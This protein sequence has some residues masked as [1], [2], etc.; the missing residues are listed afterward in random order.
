MS[1]ESE[2]ARVILPGNLIRER[3]CQQSDPALS[4]SLKPTRF[5]RSFS[6]KPSFSFLYAF[7][8]PP[9]PADGNR[10]YNRNHP[11]KPK[12]DLYTCFI[13]AMNYRC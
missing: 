7:S 6:L 12:G 8:L 3:K 2:A 10:N 9:P 1:Q 13:H 4:G 11:Q 5:N